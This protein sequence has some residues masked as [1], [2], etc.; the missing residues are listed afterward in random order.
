MKV[1]GVYISSWDGASLYDDTLYKSLNDAYTALDDAVKKEQKE[2]EDTREFWMK[3]NGKVDRMYK[4]DWKK[5]NKKQW[6]HSGTSEWL[7]I[8]EHKLK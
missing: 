7:T 8:V 3:E 2:L 4:P 1:Y 6:R 5:R